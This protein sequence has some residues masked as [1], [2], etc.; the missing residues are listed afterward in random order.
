MPTIALV[1]GHTFGAGVFLALAHDYRVQNP[2]KGFVCLPEID[3]GITI[4]TSIAVMLKY[5]IASP[6]TYRTAALEGKRLGGPETL[7]LGLVDVLGGLDEVL[8]LITERDLLK[9]SAMGSFGGIKEDAHSEILA[10]FENEEGNQKWRK[11]ID[12][13]NEE[14]GKANAKEVEEWERL[15][16]L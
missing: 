6:T 12:R 15:S 14:K 3:M 13:Q 1:N 8:K 11:E 10:A 7:K 16:K 9:K 5:K 4:P 2:S